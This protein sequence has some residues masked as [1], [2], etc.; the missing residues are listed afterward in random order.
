[1]ATRIAYALILLVNSI[2]SWLMLTDWAMKK[3]SHLTLDYVDISCNG[4]QCYGYVAVQRINFALGFFHA[5]LA[6][7]LLG[8]RSSKDGRAPIQNGF[9][10]PKIIAWIGLIILTF[11]IPNKFF[12]AWGNYFALIG[13]CLFLLIGLILLVDLAHNWA[14]Y[15]QEKIET[16]ESRVWT[17]LLIG[18]A[19][20]MYL[21][22]LAMTI[23]MYI[24][25]ARGGCSMNQASITVSHSTLLH[26]FLEIHMS[27]T[28]Y[29]SISCSFSSLQ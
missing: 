21:A 13:A 2:V 18:S 10:G 15:C 19:F 7:I 29:R 23:V 17:A 22:S 4:E 5:I 26:Y 6:I 14:E 28:I 1:M 11:F 25:F 3:L 9:W 8:V 20:F 27:N 16:T 24:F 12:I